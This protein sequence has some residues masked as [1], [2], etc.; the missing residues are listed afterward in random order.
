[1][2]E[3]PEA[4][5][6]LSDTSAW[7]TDPG[8]SSEVSRLLALAIHQPAEERMADGSF[9]RGVPTSGTFLANADVPF[10]EQQ[11]REQAAAALREMQAEGR[12]FAGKPH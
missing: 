5:T 2:Q 10:P 7:G 1:M 4:G 9:Y 8:K 11:Q 12:L 3:A 6:P